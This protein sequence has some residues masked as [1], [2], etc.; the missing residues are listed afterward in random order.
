MAT[1]AGPSCGPS[2]PGVKPPSVLRPGCCCYTQEIAPV[3]YWHQAHSSSL[4]G[5]RHFG[6]GPGLTVFLHYR[7]T[8]FLFNTVKLLWHN[9][10]CIKRFINQ[11][12]LTWYVFIL[13]PG[14]ATAG[15]GHHRALPGPWRSV[16]LRQV[17]A[18][19]GDVCILLHD[20]CHDCGSALCHLLPPASV[21]GRCT[22]PLEHSHYGCVGP[23][24]CA[25]CAAG[26]E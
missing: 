14:A 24:P 19:R 11:G 1:A 9:Q 13:S 3:D 22:L 6:T 20:C 26:K 17:F 23:G 12:D 7:H 21:S 16:S 2:A 8:I 18:D 25:Q 4:G 15:V 10:Y 5:P